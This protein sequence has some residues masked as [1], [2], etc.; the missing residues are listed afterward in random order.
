MI[1]QG[2]VEERKIR[3]WIQRC[4]INAVEM[5]VLTVFLHHHSHGLSEDTKHASSGSAPQL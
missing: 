5:L 4:F 1:P 3:P 2:H